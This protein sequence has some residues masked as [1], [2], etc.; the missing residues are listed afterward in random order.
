MYTTF[1]REHWRSIRTNNLMEWVMRKI[2]R[3]TRVVGNFLDGRSA[4]M[5]VTARLRYIAGRERGTH[6]YMDISRLL[7]MISYKILEA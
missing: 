5:M 7:G 1:P 4:L 6:R 3:R 2:R